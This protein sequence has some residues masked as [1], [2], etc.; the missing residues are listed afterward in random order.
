MTL[1]ARLSLLAAG[2]LGAGTICAASIRTIEVDYDDGVYRLVSN[3]F[4]DAPREAIFEVLTDYERFGRISSTYKEYGFLEPDED[5]IPII[6]T[7]MEGCVLFFCVSMRR[8]ERMTVAKPGFIRTDTLPE[9]SDFRFSTS[10]WTLEPEESGTSMTYRFVMEPD[11]W[12]PPL[13]GPWVLKR[14]LTRGGVGAINRIERLAR[15]AASLPVAS[16]EID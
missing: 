13:I 14:R 10:E 4:I 11:F 16:Y 1:I 5:G 8:V 12:V 7:R 3:T 15:E 2:A 6:F 9:Q